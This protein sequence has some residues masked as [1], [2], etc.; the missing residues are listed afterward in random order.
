MFFSFNSYLV[1]L[2]MRI[3]IY[4]GD[5]VMTYSI[6]TLGSEGPGYIASLSRIIL[7]PL[8]YLALIY[9]SFW[10]Y[11]FFKYWLLYLGLLII[12]S[13]KP[14]LQKSYL[15]HPTLRFRLLCLQSTPLHCHFPL[16][17]QTLNFFLIHHLR[18][19]RIINLILNAFFFSLSFFCLCL[20][21]YLYFS[22]FSF[23]FYEFSFS[24]SLV[25]SLH[26]QSPLLDLLSWITILLQCY[27][28]R[29]SSSLFVV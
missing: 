18:P 7:A 16:L 3:T 14:I 28:L 17:N 20:S 4:S 1:L 2:S 29:H 8:E 13:N 6:N 12:S 9:R 15:V 26:R 11:R 22:C 25:F 19:Y 5:K 23:L 21:P 27:R 10:P 24:A